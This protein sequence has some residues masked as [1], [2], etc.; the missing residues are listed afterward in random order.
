METDDDETQAFVAAVSHSKP[1]MAAVEAK[2]TI[3]P[4]SNKEPPKRKKSPK[5]KKPSVE[6]KKPKKPPVVDTDN[7]DEEY[8]VE[9]YDDNETHRL[10]IIFYWYGS[11][12]SLKRCVGRKKPLGLQVFRHVPWETDIPKTTKMT[13]TSLLGNLKNEADVIIFG[14]FWYLGVG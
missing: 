5:K 1:K 7:D 10:S 11:A 4:K 12:E 6:N 13:F 14:H 8:D 9:E 2:A 3:K